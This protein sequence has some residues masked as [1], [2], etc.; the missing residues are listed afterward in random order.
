MARTHG[1]CRRGTR[2]VGTIP[3]SHWK[4]TTFVTGLRHDRIVAPFVLARAMNGAT[5]LTYVERCLVPTLT[6]G[7]IVVM[8]SLS[9]HKVEG[10]RTAIEAAGA[11]FLYLPPYSPDL[12]PIELPFAKLKT[13]LR[14]AA[15]RTID[16]LWQTI[17]QL[18]DQFTAEECQSY[19]RHDECAQN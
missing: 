4:T 2:L 9:A 16:D 19:F 17:G 11:Q 5:L 6:P 1:R 14:K 15:K 10:V 18:L 13:L 8:D 12:N 3:Q 7:D